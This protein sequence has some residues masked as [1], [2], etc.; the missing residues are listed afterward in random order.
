[1]VGM[2]WQ[3]V[4]LGQVGLA[5]NDA[6]GGSAFFVHSQQGQGSGDSSALVEA[7]LQA[8]DAQ[9]GA[10]AVTAEPS[11]LGLFLTLH[12]HLY[13]LPDRASLCGVHAYPTTRQ[14]PPHQCVTG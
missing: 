8:G 1:M 4:E 3:V 9:V 5:A 10:A 2:H 13:T 12:Y 7:L 14:L 6:G 11:T